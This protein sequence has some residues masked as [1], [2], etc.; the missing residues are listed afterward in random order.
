MMLYW[1]IAVPTV[2]ALMFFIDRILLENDW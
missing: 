1:I 2:I